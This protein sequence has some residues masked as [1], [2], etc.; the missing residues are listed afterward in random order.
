MIYNDTF[1]D[2]ILNFLELINDPRA[3]K[4][5]R[6]KLKDILFLML[7]AGLSGYFTAIDIKEYCD[8]HFDRFNKILGIKQIPSHDTFS[9]VYRIVDIDEVTKN[10]GDWLM[11]NYPELYTEYNGMKVLHVDG[12]AVKAASI[13]SNGENTKYLMNAMYEGGSISLYTSAVGD[14]ENEISKIPE[15]LDKFDLKDTIVTIDAI[16]TNKNVIDK[17]HDK[18]G[19]YLFQVKN[20][21]KKVHRLIENKV[22]ELEDNGKF[23]ELD[24][25]TKSVK[26]HGR[27]EEIKTY[28]IHDTSFIY[29]ELGLDSHFSSVAKVGIMD[30]IISK[31]ENGEYV[32]T[33]T[34]TFLI[35]DLENM[36]VENIQS[37][38]LSH[39]NI[40]MQH[41]LLDVQLNEDRNTAKKFNAMTNMTI[42]KR[43]AIRIKNVVYGKDTTLRKFIIHNQL[44][45][46][47]TTEILM[48][49]PNEE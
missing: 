38:K 32:T 11:A 43:F 5:V 20:N 34:R 46:D 15:Y 21:Q 39:W 3:E 13:H 30:K 24:C 48:K 17:I 27:I 31:K 35:T 41:W 49:S 14:K 1:N 25:T 8:A 12:K 44:N 37:I 6:Y 10:I 45:F 19:K 9:R 40:E 16:G 2:D 23:D 42:I 47:R 22:K 4:G 29:K 26:N 36:S 28:M 33:K 7:H 18:G